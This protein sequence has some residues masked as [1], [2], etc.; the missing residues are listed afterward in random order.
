MVTP[1][2]FQTF[3]IQF[4]R[5]RPFTERDNRSSMKVAVVNEIFAETYLKGRDPLKEQV[6][7]PQLDERFSPGAPVTLQIVGVIHNVRSRGLRQDVPEIYIPFW[8]SP[9]PNACIGVR[10]VGDPASMAGGIAARVHSVDPEIALAYPRTMEQV[11]DDVL[12]DDH[13]TAILF[14]SFAVIALLLATIGIYGVMA[15]AAAQR[16][17]EVALRVALG[18]TRRAIISL[19]MREGIALASGG[20]ALGLIGCYFVHRAMQSTLF[21]IG[22][23]DFTA[24]GAVGLVLDCGL[25]GVLSS[26]Q[27]GRFIGPHAPVE[28][29]VICRGRER[30]SS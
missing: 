17:Q 8:Q 10:T 22:A 3:G 6:L 2:F 27:P 28:N 5:G 15:F 25:V 18:A 26:S 1:E 30:V 19:I 24:F 12:A 13:F 9:W 11:R 7:V 14:T 23:M 21:G 16:S 20:I 29:R 4:Q